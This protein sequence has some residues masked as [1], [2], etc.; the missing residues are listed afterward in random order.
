GGR[1]LAVVVAVVVAE[2]DRGR[3]LRRDQA[4]SFQEVGSGGLVRG[5]RGRGGAAHAAQHF[6]D[7]PQLGAAPVGERAVDG[8][9]VAP[10]V[11]GGGGRGG[12]VWRGGTGVEGP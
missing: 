1:Y 12:K 6:A 3:Q 2:H 8:D 5:G 11:G 10:G 9:E 4:Q 7:R